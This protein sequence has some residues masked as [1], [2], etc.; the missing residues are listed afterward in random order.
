LIRFCKTKIETLYQQTKKCRNVDF[1]SFPISLSLSIIIIFFLWLEK[2][3]KIN[4]FYI[5]IDYQL[6]SEIFST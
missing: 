3:V 6:V 5:D 2:G 1:S 4:I